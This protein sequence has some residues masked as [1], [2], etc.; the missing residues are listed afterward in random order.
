MHKTGLIGQ[1]PNTRSARSGARVPLRDLARVLAV[2]GRSA[3]RAPRSSAL[4]M[5]CSS[6]P[7]A[8]MRNASTNVRDGPID[9]RLWRG[10][11][12]SSGASIH[13]RALKTADDDNAHARGSLR[14]EGNRH[15]AELP[16]GSASRRIALHSYRFQML[17]PWQRHLPRP[18]DPSP[19]RSHET[20][21]LLPSMEQMRALRPELAERDRPRP[22]CGAQPAG[23]SGK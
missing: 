10:S 23:A 1:R 2:G 9:P 3:G 15:S 16:A 13:V 8:R 4:V 20:E 21:R 19:S 11:T 5:M 17:R 22:P 18:S 6:V 12:P 14:E 7:V